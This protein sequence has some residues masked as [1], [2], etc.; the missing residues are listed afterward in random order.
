MSLPQ[1]HLAADTQSAVV[2]ALGVLPKYLL[3]DSCAA[4]VN[5][6]SFQQAGH[7]KFEYFKIQN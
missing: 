4:E 2:E 7:L 1:V 3:I 6:F 5:E